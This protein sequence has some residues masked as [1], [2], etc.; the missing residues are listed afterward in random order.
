M[1]QA[2]NATYLLE[3]FHKLVHDLEEPLGVSASPDDLLVPPSLCRM[4]RQCCAL[5]VLLPA[6]CWSALVTVHNTLVLHTD[7]ISLSAMMA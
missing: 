1:A 5:I 4:A 6:G 7:R 2:N 3:S